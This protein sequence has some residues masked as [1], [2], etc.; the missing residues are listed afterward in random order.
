MEYDPEIHFRDAMRREKP[1]SPPRLASRLFTWYCQN[2]LQESILGDLQERFEDDLNSSGKL[3]AQTNYW[4]NVLRL[5]SRHTLKRDQ[6]SGT[7]RT[8]FFALTRIFLKLNVRQIQRNGLVSFINIFGFGLALAVCLVITLF[9]KEELSFD[10]FHANEGQ[11][12]RVSNEFVRET[13]TVNWIITPPTLAPSIRE[14][15]TAV[16]RVS[17]LRQLEDGHLFSF[18][19]KHFYEKK[20]FYADDQFLQIMEFE[21]LA[22]DRSTVLKNPYTVVLT[23]KTALKYFGNQDP[24][25]KTIK[26]D[27][28][29]SFLVTGIL[30]EIPHNSHI[31]FD[32][33]VSFATFSAQQERMDN[34]RWMGFMTYLLLSDDSDTGLLTSRIKDLY[35]QNMDIPEGMTLNVNLQPL[36]DIYLGSSDLLNPEGDFFEAGSQGLINS[37]LTIVMFILL[38]ATFNFVNLTTALSAKR[39]KE[40]GIRKILGSERTKLIIQFISE[41]VFIA[42]LGLMVAFA[43]VMVIAPVLSTQYS[44]DMVGL[45]S[46]YDITPLAIGF[47]LTLGLVAGLYP[48]L[49]LSAYKPLNA[50]RGSQIQLS[51]GRWLREGL[52]ITQFMVVI[53]LLS[54]GWIIY[55]QLKY[56]SKQELGFDKEGI[57]LLKT[58]DEAMPVSFESI[59][60]SF[61]QMPDVISTTGVNYAFDGAA[62]TRPLRLLGK[63][64]SDALQFSYYEVDFDFL[65]T[66]GIQLNAGR[67]FSKDITTDLDDAIILNETAVGLLGLENPIGE[68]IIFSRNSNKTVIGVLEDFHFASLRSS[69]GPFALVMTSGPFQYLGV[70]LHEGSL[71]DKIQKLEAHW[72]NVAPGVPF[73]FTFLDEN[74]NRM[75]QKEIQLTNL[76]GLFSG[77]SILLACMGLYGLVVLTV[78]SRLKE[79]SIRKVLGASIANLLIIQGRQFVIIV[80]IALIL[81]APLS[82]YLTNQWLNDFAYHIEPGIWIFL[83]SGLVVAM[84]A[85]ATISGQSWKASRVNPAQI[86]RNE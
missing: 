66:T 12:F 7:S 17:Q 63:T 23:R 77:L 42:L 36:S 4:I 82:W 68:K 30:E 26:M 72:S 13:G 25:G 59:S 16:E 85:I 62:A 2:E 28:Q 6:S 53:T 27:N 10:S 20:G 38:I 83:L 15:F 40:I 18:G 19:E 52:I 29:H 55:E 43:I 39:N 8:N 44:L 78:H 22:G 14:Q 9:I 86:L 1:I 57:V 64:P 51:K 41:S 73:D 32:L 81:A 54:S 21:M 80:L 3:K 58:A 56:V 33:L 74:V 50:L 24:L 70:K 65:K 69:I 61:N 11:I 71:V 46:L 45:N 31:Q 75:Y 67:F 76:I 49:I 84:I 48:S 79:I 60:T 5:V 35:T 47:T 34:W 37:L